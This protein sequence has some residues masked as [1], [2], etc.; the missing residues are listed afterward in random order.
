MTL[1]G[2]WRLN[3]SGI[4]TQYSVELGKGYEKLME[5]LKCATNE[6]ESKCNMGGYLNRWRSMMDFCL[7][8]LDTRLVQ[9]NHLRDG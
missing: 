7:G 3:L 8:S 2:S 4:S 6:E 5:L 1:P 9:V